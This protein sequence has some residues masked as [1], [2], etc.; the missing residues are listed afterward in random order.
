V[1]LDSVWLVGAKHALEVAGDGTPF[2]ASCATSRLTSCAVTRRRD[3]R[4]QALASRPGQPPQRFSWRVVTAGMGAEV[5][6][7]VDERG[8]EVLAGVRARHGEAA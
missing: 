7:V 3:G 5:G 6:G 2:P 1:G 8:A 4:R